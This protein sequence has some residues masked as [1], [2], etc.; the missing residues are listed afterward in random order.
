M[1]TFADE[2]IR[3][4]QAEAA[5]PG[6]RERIVA[7]LERTLAAVG[8]SKPDPRLAVVEAAGDVAAHLSQAADHAEFVAEALRALMTSPPQSK[9][10]A[11]G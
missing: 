10:A 8:R 4:A 1:E 2:L 6:G 5:Q 7:A 11:A 3:R 9:R